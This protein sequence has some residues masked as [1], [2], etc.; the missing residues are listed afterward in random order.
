M[1]KIYGNLD[2]L[3]SSE[4][5]RVKFKALK[6]EEYNLI[7]NKELTIDSTKFQ[8]DKVDDVEHSIEWILEDYIGK[9]NKIHNIIYIENAKRKIYILDTKYKEYKNGFL[10]KKVQVD[11]NYIGL[12]STINSDKSVISIVP[13]YEGCEDTKIEF[14]EENLSLEHDKKYV[15]FF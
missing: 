3:A 14:F 5:I 6:L 10:L 8:I 12:R 11:D 7:K 9:I 4:F 2:I 15:L 1:N 13:Y